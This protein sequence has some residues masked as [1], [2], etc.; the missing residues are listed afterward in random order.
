[1]VSSS[2]LIQPYQERENEERDRENQER[3]AGENFPYAPISGEGV[4]PDG[5]PSTS[6]SRCFYR[7]HTQWF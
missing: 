4:F 1:M 2:I 6:E 3:E 7:Y 5:S